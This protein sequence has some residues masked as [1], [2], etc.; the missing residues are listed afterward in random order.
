MFAGGGPKIIVMPLVGR[1]RNG[2][3]E[4]LSEIF[5]EL[6]LF[7][8]R[9][10]VVGADTTAVVLPERADELGDRDGVGVVT[11]EAHDEDAVLAQVVVDEARGAAAVCGAGAVEPVHE[12]QVLLDVAVPVDAERRAQRP[13]QQRAGR[14]RRHERQPEPDEQ[15]DLLVEEVDGQDALDRVAL[16]V[17]ESADLEVA[18]RHAREARR[19]RQVVARRQRPVVN[20]RQGRRSE[21]IINLFNY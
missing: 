7:W 4:R 18:H 5:G 11:D 2:R 12:A 20:I 19:R 6:R 1:G 17:A 9:G 3:E 15:E 8:R 13:Q 16:H 10:D 14:R 21:M